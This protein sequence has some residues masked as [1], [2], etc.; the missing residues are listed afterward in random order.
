[1]KTILV[2]LI[3]LSCKLVYSQT[4][5]EKDFIGNWKRVVNE[6]MNKDFSAL[7]STLSLYDDGTY[8]VEAQSVAGGYRNQTGIWELQNGNTIH[9]SPKTDDNKNYDDKYLLYEGK[10]LKQIIEEEVQGLGFRVEY[11]QIK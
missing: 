2:L 3:I 4:Y 8:K 1:M 11:K 7:S 6:V 9:L 5:E 10:R